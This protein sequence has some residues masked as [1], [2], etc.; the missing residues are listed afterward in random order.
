MAA[1]SGKP[2]PPASDL[3]LIGH[4]MNR[5]FR[6][7]WML[8]ELGLPYNLIPAWPRSDEAKKANPFGKVPALKDG[9]FTMYESAG[10][11]T[12]L[13]DK[14]RSVR[15]LVPEPG[16]QLRGRYEQITMCIVAELDSQA[17][18]IHRKHQA[19]SSTYGAIPDAV[20]HAKQHFDRTLKVLLEDLLKS[21]GDYLLGARF[22]AADI[23]FEHCLRWAHD[24][25]W[26]ASAKID[27]R[28]R[29]GLTKYRTL[30]H[31][32]PAYQ[33]CDG[34]KSKF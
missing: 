5:T 8:E 6:N 33:H 17:L 28:L 31:G 21:E 34:L 13:G 22:S 12:Y 20:A 26:L 16:T 10:I 29:E 24:I 2:L 27:A 7:V 15:E 4:P 9:D 3:T 14:F 30:C 23:L 19:L 11:N 18:W 32:R 25:G 1:D